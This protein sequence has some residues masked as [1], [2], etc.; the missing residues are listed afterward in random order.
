MGIA[1]GLGV[2][3]VAAG[4]AD[5]GAASEGVIDRGRISEH[6]ADGALLYTVGAAGERVGA[7]ASPVVVHGGQ[8]VMMSSP[9]GLL[10]L[11]CPPNV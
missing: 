5:E 11:L 2:L 4:H 7:D 10:F 6:A 9:D 1:E 8:L 3:G